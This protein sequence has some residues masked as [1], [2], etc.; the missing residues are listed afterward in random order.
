MGNMTGLAAAVAVAASMGVSGPAAA[1]G[2]RTFAVPAG[3]EAFLTVQSRACT[4]AHYWTCTGEPDGTFWRVS[5]DQDGP[6]Y[7]SYSDAEYRWLQ[8][9][10]LRSGSESI[11]MTPEE[12]P[13]SVTDLLETGTDSMSFSMARREG[14]VT[15]QRN[16]TGFDSLTGDEVV[17][18]GE[19]LL[20]TEFAYRYEAAEGE[21]SVVGNQFISPERRLFFG[22][23]ET[24][25]L[26][27]GE[28]FD[29]DYSP[30][31]FIEPGEDNFLTMNPIYDCGST[32][33]DLG[34]LLPEDRG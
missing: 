19:R 20:L 5:I 17:I 3:C 32:V 6:F 33:S 27:T 8:N 2:G 14:T 34:R 23:I 12:D 31:E 18:D 13:A 25:T 30:R 26:S 16:Y 21:R 9:Y 10:D 28:S 1:Q 7:L 24:M 29:S 22:G 4:V 11:L 15:Y